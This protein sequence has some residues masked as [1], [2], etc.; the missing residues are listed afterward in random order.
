M[1]ITNEQITHAV[2]ADVLARFLRYV[3]VHTTSDRHSDTTPS[4]QRQF[5][6]ARILEGELQ[7]LGLSDVS[8]TDHCYVCGRLPGTPGCTAPPVLFLAHMDTAP[9][10]SGA[11]VNPQLWEHY[12]GTVLPI[13]GGRVLDPGEYPDLLRYVGETVI[14]TDGTTLLGADDKA[15]VAEI[16]SALRFLV[17]HPEITHGEVEVI[18]TPDEEIGRGVNKLPMEWVH[19]AFGFTMD[20]GREGSIEVECFNAWAARVSIQGY[21]IHPGYAKN[22]LVNAITLAGAFLSALPGRETPEATAGRDGFYCPVEVTG[23]QSAAEIHFIIRDFDRAEID[24]RIAVLQALGAGI[25]AAHPGSTITVTAEQQYLNMYE[26]I[27]QHPELEL[28]LRNAVEAAGLEPIVE[29]IRGGTD[30]S[31]LT[32]MGLPTPNIFAGGHNFHGPYEWIALPAL[33]R[34]TST[35]IHLVQKWALQ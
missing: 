9:D 2:Q 19:S 30:G 14:T 23:D 13:G 1:T 31:R 7:E 29:P 27:S 10:F 21:A 4:S 11:G 26:T 35:I 8:V 32:E 34:A 3:K 25:Q 28:L 24:R 17:E 12:D 33:V 15:G 18:F 20:G 16:M 5:D 22:R 6:L